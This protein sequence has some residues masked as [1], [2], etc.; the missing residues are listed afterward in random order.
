MKTHHDVF[1]IDQM[2][3]ILGVSRS[4]Y[5]DYL[6]RG[7]SARALDNKKLVDQMKLIFEESHQ[8]YGRPRLHAALKDQGFACSRPRVARLMKAH[9]M[10]AKMSRRFKTTTKRSALSRLGSTKLSSE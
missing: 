4:G 9:G 6:K 7:L 8:T 5:Y 10:Q 1:S 2:A 3:G